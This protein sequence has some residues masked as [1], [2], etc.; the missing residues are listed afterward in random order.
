[1]DH[2]CKV[3][4]IAPLA[5]MAMATRRRNNWRVLDALIDNSWLSYIDPNL[6]VEGWTQCIKLW[7]AIDTMDLNNHEPDRFI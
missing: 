5:V 6:S 7:E 1:M 2:G 3:E 4:D